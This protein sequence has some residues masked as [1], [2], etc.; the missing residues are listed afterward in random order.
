MWGSYIHDDLARDPCEKWGYQYTDIVVQN[1]QEPDGWNPS[2]LPEIIN[3]SD[4]WQRYCQIC[5]SYDHLYDPRPSFFP[6]ISIGNAPSQCQYYGDIAR[7]MNGTQEGAVNLGYALHFI[8]DVGC[9]LHAGA[10]IVQVNDSLTNPENQWVHNKYDVFLGDHW[11]PANPNAISLHSVVKNNYGYEVGDPDTLTRNL[12]IESHRYSETIFYI[13]WSHPD[14]YNDNATLI[15]DTYNMMLLSSRYNLGLVGYALNYQ[16]PGYTLTLNQGWNLVSMPLYM[17]PIMA[18][19]VVSNDIPIVCKYNTAIGNYDAFINGVSKPNYDF[20]VDNSQG[21]WFY[22]NNPTSFTVYGLKPLDDAYEYEPRNQGWNIIDWLSL[23]SS[24]TAKDICTWSS[25]TQMVARYNYSTGQ[26]EIYRENRTP[27][28]DNFN[29]IPGNGYFVSN[30]YYSDALKAAN[31]F[32]FSQEESSSGNVTPSSVYGWIAVNGIPTDGVIVS[33]G[34]QTNVTNNG[35]YYQI[36]LSDGM[37]TC[38]EASYNGNKIESDVFTLNGSTTQIDLDI[39]GYSCVKFH[40]IPCSIDGNLTDYQVQFLMHNTTGTDTAKDIYFNGGSLSWPYDF[41]FTNSN[42][43][44]LSYWIESNTTDTAVVWVKV[45]YIAASGST[46]LNVYYGK[47]DDLGDSN[48]D[49]TFILFDDF[50]DNSINSSKWVKVLGSGSADVYE[51]DGELELKSGRGDSSR[52]FLRTVNNY[53]GNY[54]IDVDARYSGNNGILLTSYW[55]GLLTGQWMGPK[56]CYL[57]I[58]VGWGSPSKFWEITKQ[59]NGANYVLQHNDNN[60]NNSFHKV[61][62]VQ[63]PQIIVQVDGTTIMTGSSDQM[64][65]DGYIGL[66]CREGQNSIQTFYDNFHIR[67]YTEHPPVADTGFMMAT[68][69]FIPAGPLYDPAQDTSTVKIN[70]ITISNSNSSDSEAET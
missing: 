60:M 39:N 29:L 61:T 2:P 25:G 9:P 43:Q 20:V 46:R 32:A 67:K 64:F 58:F 13:I 12:G 59:V 15:M 69:T 34:G 1:C 45:D 57:N 62:V 3:S 14:T 48:G 21:Y 28:A 35:G 5:H 36:D 47:E 54:I 44:K 24:K 40:A 33:C 56:N 18:S 42:N 49:A 31:N 68:S 41:R 38:I 4:V 52:P 11:D 51:Q 7:S 16:Q 10:E 22:C 30:N 23:D 70:N 17:Q 19:N 50:D 63:K 55:D 8:S 37:I 65:T 26:F 66:G 53:T 27:D 6:F